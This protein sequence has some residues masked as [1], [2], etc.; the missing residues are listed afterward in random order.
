MSVRSRRAFTL[1]ELLVVIAIIAVLIALLLP[2][3][4]AAREAARRS[5]C[6]NNLKQLGLAVHNYLSQ[7]NCFPPVV[8]NISTP[9]AILN[10]D[11]NSNSWP[12]D[13]AAS[14]LPQLEQQPLY[15]ALNFSFA[16]GDWT[17]NFANSTVMYTKISVM[18]C[19]S[20]NIKI[21][22]IAPHGFKN[23]V[24]NCGGPPVIYAWTGVIAPLQPSMNNN[25]GQSSSGYINGNCGSFGVEGVTDGT[26]NTAMFSETLVGSGPV[27][28]QVTISNAQRPTTYLFP[29]NQNI[30]VDQGPTAGTAALNF[31]QACKALPGSTVAFGTLAPAS[32]NVWIAG[33]LN[34]TMI[35]DCYNHWMPPNSL[36]CDN[37][38]DGNTGGYGSYSD[39]MPPS[40]NHPGG[41]N[42]SMADGHVQFLKNTVAYQSWWAIGTRSSG[43]VISSDSY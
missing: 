22:S 4:Q 19:P 8:Q 32:G 7:Q 15:N 40:S 18:L 37:Q 1:I 11:P 26:S 42:I 34:S 14:L 12:L 25:P 41:V 5:Q 27:A 13:W 21:P 29:V 16:G 20:E 31:V 36:G 30:P 10:A 33:N 24:A 2:A 23:Y 6:T 17:P 35:W 28:N 3:V 39:A 9:V 43:E 38:Y